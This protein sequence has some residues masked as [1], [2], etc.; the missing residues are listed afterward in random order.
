MATRSRMTEQEK[1]ACWLKQHTPMMG[2]M[3]AALWDR[4]PGKRTV[5][6]PWKKRVRQPEE[7][8]EPEE[9]AAE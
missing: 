2:T 9:A 4:D 6:E 5:A 8:E 7:P 3:A 1:R